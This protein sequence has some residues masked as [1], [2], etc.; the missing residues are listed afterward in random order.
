MDLWDSAVF[1]FCFVFFFGQFFKQN[2]NWKWKNLH[3]HTSIYDG[4]V[5]FDLIWFAAVFLFTSPVYRLFLF[6]FR[7]YCC[8]CCSV[9]SAS[10]S[11]HQSLK[12]ICFIVCFRLLNIPQICWWFWK[13][14][15]L[16]RCWTHRHTHT[17]FDG[18]TL[19]PFV[20]FRFARVYVCVCQSMFLPSVYI[21]RSLFR[22]PSRV[23]LFKIE[24]KM[25]ISF[26]LVQF[27][28]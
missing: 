14:S 6:F 21:P 5:W 24:W 12:F 23:D 7:C 19:C 28:I 8:W 25:L 16:F 20:S 13:L 1:G 18:D 11:F 9:F 22:P 17:L 10:L 27:F 4:V 3:F 15:L 26:H 2:W